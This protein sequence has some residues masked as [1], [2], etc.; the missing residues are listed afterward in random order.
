MKWDEEGYTWIVS[1]C[2]EYQLQLLDWFL[3]GRG[4]EFIYASLSSW[5]VMRHANPAD[6][7]KS[8]WLIHD[9]SSARRCQKSE[10]IPKDT[11][12]LVSILHDNRQA[13]DRQ[14]KWNE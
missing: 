2:R 13:E 4:V 8:L 5:D 12:V 11:G 3:E 9:V 1:H 6:T 7:L 10:E 14:R